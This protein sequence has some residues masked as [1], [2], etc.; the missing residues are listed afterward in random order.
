[1]AGQI[2]V[3]VDGAVAELDRLAARTRDLSPVFNGAVDRIVLGFLRRQFETAGVA[4]GTPWAPLSEVTLEL[5]ARARRARMGILRFSNRLFA[6]LT[7]RSSPDELFLVTAQSYTRG[8]RVPYALFHQ[9]GYVTGTIFGRARKQPRQVPARPLIP[10]A[11]LP[12]AETDA[13]ARAVERYITTGDA[14]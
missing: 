7:K 10:P 12:Q 3:R 2:T 5:K 1:M 13:I 6:S 8:T 9:T 14:G 4:G 11:G